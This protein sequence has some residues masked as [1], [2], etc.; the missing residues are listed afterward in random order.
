MSMRSLLLA[1]RDR[2]RDGLSYREGECEVG[3]DGMPQP[4]SGQVYVAVHPGSVGNTQDQCLDESY[5]VDIT[6]SLKMGTYPVDK[7]G[8]PGIVLADTGLYARAEAIRA[9]IHM[10][11]VSMNNA[12]AGSDYSIG[13][14]ENGF[15]EP[16]K[17][18]GMGSPTERDPGWWWSESQ[19][20]TQTMA[21]SGLSITLSFNGARR[22]QVI[23]EQS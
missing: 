4:R 12:N 6:L 1:T 18:A 10:D 17:F 15:I 11:Y 23:E 8:N 9:L 21:P 2:L 7:W 19:T 5:S 14:L 13:I 3:W 16:L 20:Q 22:V